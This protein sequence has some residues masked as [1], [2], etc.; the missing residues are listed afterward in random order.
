MAALTFEKAHRY[1]VEFWLLTPLLIQYLPSSNYCV[2]F[3]TL[4]PNVILQSQEC[5]VGS[6]TNRLFQ[7]H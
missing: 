1:H 7:K 6:V 2:P 4:W 5:I 3:V